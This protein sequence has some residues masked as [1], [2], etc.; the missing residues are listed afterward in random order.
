[1]G[2]LELTPE[3]LL[4]AY[5]SGVFPMAERRDDSAV[6]LVDPEKRGIFPLDG[7]HISRS[8]AR[9][10]RRQDYEIAINRNFDGVVAACADRKETWINRTIFDLYKALHQ[11][12]FAHS[13]E[14]WQGRDL[15]GGVYGVT[16]GGA[17]FGE[18]MFSRAANA[19]KI[20]LAYLV[21][22]L[23]ETGFQLFD[24]QFLTPHLASLGAIEIGR[25]AY[26]RRLAKALRAK[27]DF[28]ADVK[29]PL[30]YGI[31]QRNT[32]IS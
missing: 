27:G 28:C 22:R 2:G 5:A 32:Q 1:M 11:Q 9:R 13:L 14:V 24:A 3:S 4:E 19:S 17:F 21:D 10:L 29:I 31:I 25:A 8:L 7:F 26:R 12:G 23:R 16:L 18:S 6:F 20:A 15:S 30:P